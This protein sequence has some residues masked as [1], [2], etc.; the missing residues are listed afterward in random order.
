MIYSP[1]KNPKEAF[2][3]IS[4]VVFAGI[5]GSILLSV[6]FAVIALLF[7]IQYTAVLSYLQFRRKHKHKIK[8][9][10]TFLLNPQV[11][12]FVFLFIA[13]I[14]LLSMFLITP[15]IAYVSL[16]AWWLFSLNFYR[17]YRQFKE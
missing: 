15:V 4:A 17:Y 8:N 2:I 11:R 1:S 13:V 16:F 9:I 12:F 7:W 6:Y 5:A 14:G 3:L 10:T